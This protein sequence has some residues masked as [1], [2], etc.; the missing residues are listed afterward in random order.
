MLIFPNKLSTKISQPVFGRGEEPDFQAFLN[1]CKF[2]SPNVN[3]DLLEKAFQFNLEANRNLFRKSGDPYYVHSLEIATFLVNNLMYNDE[4]I[5]SALM[6]DI[7]GKSE[8]ITTREIQTVF[9]PVIS[10]I[11]E[12]V[13]KIT[14]LEKQGIGDIEYFRRLIL[15][16]TTDVRIIFIKIAD[17]Y[18]D[19]KTINFLLPEVQRKLAEDTMQIYVPLAHRFGFYVIKSELE[20]IA[21][22]VLDKENYD[23]IA[24]KLRMTKRDRDKYLLDFAKPIVEKL[25]T[26]SFLDFIRFEIHGRVKHIYS[27][28]KKT[29]LRGKPVDELYDLI[30]LRIILDT[31]DETICGKVMEEIKK[32]YPYLPETYKDYIKNP[33]PNGYQSIHCAFIGPGNEKVEVQVRTRKMHLIAEKGIAA[34]YRYKSDFVSVDSI[35]EDPQIERWVQE[36]RDLIAKKES[37]PT[38][39][40]L[41]SFKYDIFSNEIYVLTPKQEIK[42]LPKNASVLDFAYSI[43]T[44]VGNKCAGVKINNRTASIFTPL[45]NGDVVEVILSDNLEPELSWFD[46]VVTSKAKNAILKFYNQKKAEHQ[47]NGEKIF[48]D[49]LE[50]YGLTQK[51]TKIL[52]LCLKILKYSNASEFY[53]ELSKIKQ[54]K[55]VTDL[56]IAFLKRNNL[57]I[58]DELIKMDNS[59]IP[60]RVYLEENR[61]Q[62]DDKAYQIIYSDCCLPVRG[63]KIVSYATFDKIYVHRSECP[64]TKLLL[65]EEH[66]RKVDFGWDMTSKD[67][68]E[69]GVKITAKSQEIIY[70][71]LTQ[72]FQERGDVLVK[73]LY[74]KCTGT[75]TTSFI[76][77]LTVK[78][79]SFFDRIAEVA[80]TKSSDVII[81]RIGKFTPEDQ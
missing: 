65:A 55:N 14:S 68:F 81:E 22:R 41:E 38:E 61:L 69:M 45:K 31:D 77:I 80:K 47:R 9:G 10:Q 71:I 32:I 43:H 8:L 67:S 11:V 7:L 16:I 50:N 25:K 23:K 76:L 72:A 18:Q 75:E 33:K 15:A 20:D 4:L 29:L 51:K 56:L 62:I 2:F 24:R 60:L 19:M 74:K 66:T 59:L 5:A 12:N 6:H 70:S 49:L 28:Y 37:V 73:A 36:I 48:K 79:N 30:G 26:L 64:N 42:I 35:F 63:D 13:N 40:L 17:R 27:I 78:D 52:N 54:L 1:F 58:N 34:H 46:K 3:V 21:F 44:D 57:N 39:K 53:I